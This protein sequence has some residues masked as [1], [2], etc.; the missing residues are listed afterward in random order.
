MGKLLLPIL[1]VT[2]L[3]T[4]TMSMA[5]DDLSRAKVL[6]QAVGDL[7]K[8]GVN[9]KALVLDLGLLQEEGN[10]RFVLIYKQADDKWQ[11]W[12]HL[13]GGVMGDTDGGM[14]GDPFYD[15]SISRGALVF[16]HFGGSSYKWNNIHRFR[17]NTVS[18]H[19]ELIG[20]T[21]N[22]GVNMGCNGFELDYNLVTHK[23]IYQTYNDYCTEDKANQSY[24]LELKANE[25]H[26]LDGF[27]PGS[28]MVKI[29]NLD[30]TVYY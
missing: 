13:H 28:V 12:K 16:S 22:Y 8:D 17:F 4:S 5:S 15:L 18:N 7:D 25:I 23:A 24:N 10:D 2:G 3:T 6:A 20:A 27:L 19:F 9:E 14:I 29:P 11:L 30:K 1:L 21:V 26:T